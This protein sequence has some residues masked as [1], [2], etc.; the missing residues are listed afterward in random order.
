MRRKLPENLRVK[1]IVIASEHG[2]GIRGQHPIE[3]ITR[4]REVNLTREDEEA[5]KKICEFYGADYTRLRKR[6]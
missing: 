1:L 3:I 5:I 4:L 2:V 6:A